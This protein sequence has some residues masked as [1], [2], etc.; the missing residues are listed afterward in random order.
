[1]DVAPLPATIAGLPVPQDDVSRAAWRWAYGALPGYLLAHSVRSYC[2]GAEIGAR[3][4]WRFDERILWSA[5]L[6][7]D[8]GLTTTRSNTMCFEVEGAERAR[9]TLEGF[10]MDASSADRAAIAIILH[11]QPGVTLDDGVEAVLL[12]RATA[13][14]VRGV[15]IDLVEGV[16]SGVTGMFPRGAFDRL[17]V[18]AISREVARRRDCQSARLLGDGDLVGAMA[19]SPW[20]AEARP[21]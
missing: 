3:E 2:W 10:G 7:H 16:R 21:A 9:R 6:F 15:Q 20:A 5:A 11:M 12:D 18:R 13:V 17:F 14:D 4:G 8:V 19:R 1:M